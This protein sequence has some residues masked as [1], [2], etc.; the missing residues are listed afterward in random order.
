LEYLINKRNELFI[1]NR[2]Y[3]IVIEKDYKVQRLK[4]SY[5]NILNAFRNYYTKFDIKKNDKKYL[6]NLNKFIKDE[7]K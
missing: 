4:Y 3:N 5:D 1:E 7:E 2:S 6:I